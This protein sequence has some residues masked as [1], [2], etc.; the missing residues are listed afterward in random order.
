MFKLVLYFDS[1]VIDDK[2]WHYLTTSKWNF[3]EPQCGFEYADSIWLVAERNENENEMKSISY[4]N[5]I[6]EYYV[7]SLKKYIHI[8]C[9]FI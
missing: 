1:T 4:Y 6:S 7:S 5:I 2:I 3:W 8:T 9:F